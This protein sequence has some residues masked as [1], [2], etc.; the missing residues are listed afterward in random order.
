MVFTDLK[1]PDARRWAK[2]IAWFT[3]EFWRMLQAQKEVEGTPLVI[4]HANDPGHN[5]GLVISKD[6]VA[7][8]IDPTSLGRLAATKEFEGSEPQ[9][10][11]LRALRATLSEELHHLWMLYQGKL[12][13]SCPHKDNVG[14]RMQVVEHYNEF[15]EYA[16][17]WFTHKATG[18]RGV[19]LEI[20]EAYRAERYVS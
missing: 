17:L 20:V 19:L 7:V 6:L 1:K 12:N 5:T 15:V 14:S 18:E 13:R 16:A 11:L 8:R 2:A 9:E 4:F 3:R 10:R